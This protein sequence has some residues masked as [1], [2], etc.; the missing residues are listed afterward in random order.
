[1]VRRWFSVVIL[2][3]HQRLQVRVLS[4]SIFFSTFVQMFGLCGVER[5]MM[6]FAL[7]TKLR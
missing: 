2:E 4:T 6:V 3:N 1:M 7:K 5:S